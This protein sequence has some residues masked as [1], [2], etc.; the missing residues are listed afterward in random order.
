MDQLKRSFRCQYEEKDTIGKR[1]RRHDAIGTPF[2]IT[3]DHETL[4]E[5][6]VTVRYRDSMEQQRVPVEQLSALIDSKVSLRNL[7]M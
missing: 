2:C 5:N 1:Y 6:S 4:A 3:V 7:L